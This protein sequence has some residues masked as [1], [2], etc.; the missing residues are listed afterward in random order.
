MVSQSQHAW[1]QG[2]IKGSRLEMKMDIHTVS[3]FHIETNTKVYS[4][5]CK[6]L[7]Y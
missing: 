5:F 4:S 7:Y 6:E 1:G 3:L 2:G